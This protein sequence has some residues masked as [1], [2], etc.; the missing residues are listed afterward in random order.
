[1]RWVPDARRH[2]F[3]AYLLEPA[4]VVV[5]IGGA[6]AIIAGFMPWA[7]GQ[8]PGLHGF[9]R[10]FF[11]GLGGAGDGVMLIVL[12]LATGFLTLH[13]T[14]ATSRV[15]SIRLAPAVLVAL[16]AA[17]W[18]TGHRSALEAIDGW[19][20][21]G[22]RGEIAVG[23]WLAAAAIGLMAAGS[24]WLL[25]P[26]IRWQTADDDPAD[27]VRIGRR[28][29]IEVVGGVA[30]TFAGGVAGVSGALALTGPTLVGTIALGAVF[31]GLLGAYLGARVAGSVVDRLMDRD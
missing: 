24:A 15:R 13:R 2:P 1:M 17:T 30:G 4:R 19:V 3:A 14:P 18:M 16:S 25:P 10:V 5:G 20:R 11:S 7:E 28:D 27:L 29:V 31:G 26:V 22:G 6:L 12:G 9:E 8:A 21:A 23:L